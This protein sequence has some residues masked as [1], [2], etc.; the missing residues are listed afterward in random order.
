MIDTTERLR[1][2]N[3]EHQADVLLL[4][5]PLSKT[6]GRLDQHLP[7]GFDSKFESNASTLESPIDWFQRRVP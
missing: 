4:A 5:Q 1:A 7:I 2:G 6:V 3:G